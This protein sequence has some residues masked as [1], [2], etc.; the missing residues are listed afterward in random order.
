MLGLYEAVTASGKPYYLY[1]RMAVRIRVLI[2]VLIGVI[3][4]GLVASFGC[5]A[6]WQ[7]DAWN[8][9]AAVYYFTPKDPRWQ[10]LWYDDYLE[11]QRKQQH[12]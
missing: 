1:N 3:L 12:R 10:W 8:H 11:L 4:G 9:H 7:L 2:G 6:K 5:N